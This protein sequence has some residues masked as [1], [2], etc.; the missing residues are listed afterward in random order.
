M[1]MLVVMRLDDMRR[2]HPDQ[3]NSRFCS[4]CGQKVGIYPSG[5]KALKAH[6]EMTVIC[7]VC[8][9]AKSMRLT[10]EVP[11]APWPEIRQESR[12]SFDVKKP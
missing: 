11:A 3:D 7:S 6:P 12:A 1:T 9:F 5:Q 10:A 8:S 2:Q 4:E